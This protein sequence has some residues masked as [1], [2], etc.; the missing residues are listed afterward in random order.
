MG[1][2]EHLTTVANTMNTSLLN[3][4]FF[5]KCLFTQATVPFLTVTFVCCII[6]LVKKTTKK[7]VTKE[8]RFEVA[9]LTR[10]RTFRRRKLCADVLCTG[11]Y[12]SRGSIA[13]TIICQWQRYELA[14]QSIF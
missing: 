9:S 6:L 12:A 11:I 13:V 5:E 4:S 10:S 14:I 2:V 3:L 1:S 8:V 7:T